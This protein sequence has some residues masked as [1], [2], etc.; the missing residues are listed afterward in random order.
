MD[1]RIM[2]SEGQYVVYIKANSIYD[3]DGKKPYD[4]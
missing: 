2:T 3:L 4:L 1:G